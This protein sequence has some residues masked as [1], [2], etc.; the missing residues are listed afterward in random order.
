MTPL[1]TVP[2]RLKKKGGTAMPLLECPVCGK[3]A[4]TPARKLFSDALHTFPCKACGRNLRVSLTGSVLYGAAF[5]LLL[6][7]LFLG[8]PKAIGV[9]VLIPIFAFLVWCHLNRIPLVASQPGLNPRS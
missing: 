8:I 3:A 1:L 4:T 6:A 7:L 2:V 9:L 5:C